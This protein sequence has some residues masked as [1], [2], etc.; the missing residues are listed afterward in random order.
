MDRKNN[1]N[2]LEEKIKNIGP[3]LSDKSYRPDPTTHNNRLII[4]RT[5]DEK[6]G[7]ITTPCFPYLMHRQGVVGSF[8]DPSKELKNDVT[9]STP[10]YRKT[11]VHELYH[12]EGLSEI[13]VRE[14]TGEDFPNY[15]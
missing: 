2:Y 7:A 8:Y 3:T 10:E 6:T 11:Q 1:P 15:R 4:K 5:R 12:A 14:R 13:E 9:Q